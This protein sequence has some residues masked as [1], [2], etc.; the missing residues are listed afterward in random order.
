MRACLTRCA[1]SV[2]GPRF[3]FT[4]PLFVVPST[5]VASEPSDSATSGASAEVTVTPVC[6]IV[7]LGTI[8]VMA[9][10]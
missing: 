7:P 8:V 4:V 2:A 6:A 3:S 1:D 5:R 10:S 9:I